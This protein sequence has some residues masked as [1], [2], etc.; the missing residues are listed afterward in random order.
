MSLT[1]EHSAE[2][3]ANRL[4][5]IGGSDAKRIMAGDWFSLWEEKT[6]RAEGD[7]LSNILPVQMG[8]FTEPLNLFWF[9]KQTG[10][11]VE[12]HDREQRH[13]THKFM[14]CELDGWSGAPVEA[15]HVNHFTSDE[16]VV[17]N[18]YPQ[19]Q[20]QMAIVDSSMLYLSVL[21]GN[22]RWAYFEVARDD[23]YIATLIE[24][25]TAFWQHVTEDTPPV[26]PNAEGVNIALDDMR[27]VDMS[28]NNEWASSAH[29]WQ[30]NE[31]AKK[32]FDTTTKAIKAMV[33]PDVKLASGHGIVAKRS[34]SGA[35]SIRKE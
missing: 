14:R 18:Y 23:D 4:T 12:T 31:A 1:L 13:K 32:T 26:D 24:R 16:K 7:D 3:H 15:K 34:K 35:I 6:G 29:V 5:G 27:T 20:H 28:G 11:K 22:S 17:S 8:S 30:E 9:S 10:L 33:E 21:F 2:W 19:M 25:E